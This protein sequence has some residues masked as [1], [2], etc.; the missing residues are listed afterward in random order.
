M[1]HH[2]GHAF[3]AYYGSPF[4]NEDCLIFTADAYGDGLS[5]T[6]SI[7]RDDRV[8]RIMKSSNFN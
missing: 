2:P 3:Y 8:E 4:R 1:E 6:I 7:A 5:A